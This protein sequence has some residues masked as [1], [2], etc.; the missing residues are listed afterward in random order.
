MSTMLGRVSR[1]VPRW[2]VRAYAALLGA[3][4][5]LVVAGALL[6]SPDDLEAGR[7]VVSPPCPVRA[8]TGRDCPSCGL[9]RGVAA[10]G[11][12]QWSRALAYNRASPVALAL[13]VA[14][15]A[16][17]AVVAARARQ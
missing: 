1:P 13:A 15:V 8:R 17:C 11:H 3:G 12:G 16:G 5:G 14:I 9:T 4:A 7:V 6:V 10:L 2:F